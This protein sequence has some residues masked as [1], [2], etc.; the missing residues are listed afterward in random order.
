MIGK[1]AAH[2][3]WFKGSRQIPQLIRHK[4]RAQDVPRPALNWI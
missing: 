4:V 3:R 1:V 2:D